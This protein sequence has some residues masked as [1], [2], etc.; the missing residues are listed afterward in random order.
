VRVAL[1]ARATAISAGN[2][3]SGALTTDGGV[4]AWGVNYD[5]Q[6]GLGDTDGRDAP[7]R[8]AS[9]GEVRAISTGGSHSL[10]L[11][12]DGSVFSWGRSDFGQLGDG[13]LASRINPVVVV[14]ENGAGSVA[15]N[16]WFLDLDPAVPT[17]IPADR[18]PSFLVVASASASTVT[19]DIRYRA[20]DVGTTASTFVF[21]L[22]PSGTCAARPPRNASRG[23]RRAGGRR[24]PQ[25]P[26]R[27]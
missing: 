24:N 15:G 25:G 22:A 6:L 2:S 1:P 4:W 26:R 16:D 5:G 18:V 23:R 3:G 10:A 20:Q 8:L 17:T 11:R 12:A 7:V 27:P 14:R 13:T 21:A 9:L 19:A